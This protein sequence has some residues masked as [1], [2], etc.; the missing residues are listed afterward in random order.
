MLKYLSRHIF[1]YRFRIKNFILN[2]N[3]AAYYLPGARNITRKRLF[4]KL[5]EN[6]VKRLKRRIQELKWR[7]SNRTNPAIN[8]SNRFFL[9][10]L[11][12]L[13]IVV[14]LVDFSCEYVHRQNIYF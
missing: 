2:K 11:F 3:I 13:I 4:K 10:T 7:I 14:D 1:H 9:F 8:I 6:R 12:N 5:P